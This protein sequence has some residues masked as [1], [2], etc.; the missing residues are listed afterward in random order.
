MLEKQITPDGKSNAGMP[1]KIKSVYRGKSARPGR[2][3]NNVMQDSRRPYPY[4]GQNIVSKRNTSENIRII[5]L[6]G[7][8]E[9]G[10]NM[11]AIE[12]KDDIIII[13]AG[14]Q[15]PEED[16]PGVDYLIP[17][18]QYLEER[19]ERI[20]GI[21]ISHGHLD[22]VG[23]LPYLSER[24]GNPIIYTSKLSKAMILKRYEEFPHIAKPEI[25]EVASKDKIKLGKNFAAK[26]FDIEHTIPDAIGIIVE[27]ELGNI[28]Y[29]GDFKIEHDGKG[30]PVKRELE[31]FEEIGKENNLLL[32]MES[33]NVETPGFS[34]PEK[35]VHKNLEEL[36]RKSKGRIITA[37]FASLLE[38]VTE[39]VKIAEKLDRKVVIDGYSLKTNLEM[40]QELGYVKIKKGVIIQAGEIDNYPPEKILAI[41]TGSQGEENAALVRI[42]NKKHKNIRIKKGDTIF[43]SSSVV[44]GNERSVQNLKDNLSRQG[45]K[46]IHYK[47]AD[48]H[49]SGHAYAGELELVHKIIKPKFFIPIHGSY[50][51]LSVHKELAESTGM[52]VE[53]I[54]IPSH[55]GVII[56]VSKDKIEEI[57]EYAPSSL[58]MVDGLGVGDVKEVVLRDRQALAQDGIFVIIAVIDTNTGKVKNSPDI[59]SRGFVYLRESQELL[60]A[61]RFLIRKTIE[62]AT[63]EMHPVNI[64]YVKNNLRERV[65]DFLFKK[66]RR[67]PMVLP[68]ILEV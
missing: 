8:E 39:M 52:P 48:I 7:V 23:G 62:E 37:V 5:P 59:I 32:L 36:F 18:T 4:P 38:R 56:E 13:D 26:F 6:G 41:C 9:I 51:M 64:D 44:P 57:K 17:N 29:P 16:H 21:M 68:V 40:V 27:T 53:N 66:T 54:V 22:H 30:K 46:I 24:I 43:L 15:F 31:K 11:T 10:K 67:R 14:V 58:V 60:R 25:R 45:A 20:R 33:T 63:V 42:A 19:K 55:N 1:P 34:L 3:R 12:Y 65:A 47:M 35:Q 61:T 28:I 49:S 50:F 2:G